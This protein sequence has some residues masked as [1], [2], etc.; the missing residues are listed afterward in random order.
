MIRIPA[1]NRF[2]F[3]LADGAVNPYLLPAIV[4]AAGLDGLE[5]NADPGAPKTY[6]AYTTPPPP[7]TEILSSSLLESLKKLEECD[8]GMKKRLGEDFIA[9]Y[10]KLRREEW[11][12]FLSKISDWEIDNTVD[13]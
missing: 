1:G 4:L 8:V 5:T 2:E 12:L 7:G 3:R 10:L 11:E 13:C 6:N 9:S